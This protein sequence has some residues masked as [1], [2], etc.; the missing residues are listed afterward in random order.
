M[1][2]YGKNI[3]DYEALSLI[4]WRS[5]RST[6]TASKVLQLRFYW[7]T[8]FEDYYASAKTCDRCQCTRNISRCHELPLTI[9]FEVELF[10]AWGIDFMNPFPP[11]FCQVYILL[12]IDYVSKWVEAIATPTNDAKAV[13]KFL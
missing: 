1:C 4:L 10:D 11:S 5:F 6:L 13:I 8:L 7:P 9:M 3:I 12:A 2:P